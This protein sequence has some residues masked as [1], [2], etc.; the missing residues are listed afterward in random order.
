MGG[1]HHSQTKNQAELPSPGSSPAGSGSLQNDGAQIG[2]QSSAELCQLR[3]LRD[4]H[5]QIRQQKGKDR[6]GEIRFV[7]RD[8]EKQLSNAEMQLAPR[9]F[10][11]RALIER[12]KKGPV[13]W[14]PGDPEENPTILWPKTR[15]EG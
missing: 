6:A 9:D 14:E 12:T 7:P 15:E 4:S 11:E 1:R 5:L 13:R 10:L 3:L 8:G 2:K